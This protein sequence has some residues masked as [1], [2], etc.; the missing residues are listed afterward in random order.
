MTEECTMTLNHDKISTNSKWK[1][2][3]CVIPSTYQIDMILK[4]K[5]DI[6]EYFCI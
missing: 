6:T 5:V 1:Y 2:V 3:P 4:V